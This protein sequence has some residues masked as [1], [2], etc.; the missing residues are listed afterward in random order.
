MTARC[1]AL[2]ARAAGLRSHLLDQAARQ[3]CARPHTLGG[4]ARELA[5]RGYPIESTAPDAPDLE[6]A[7]RRGAA[8]RLR[9]LARWDPPGN[10]TTILL[11]GEELRALR[12]LVRGAVEGLPAEARLAGLI[13]TPRLP[14]SGLDL[15]ARQT[16]V[17]DIAALLTR[18]RSPWAEAFAAARGTEPDLLA[19]ETGLGRLFARRT[20]AAASRSCRRLTEYARESVDLLNLRSAVLLAGRTDEVD[21][22]ALFLPG[23][24]LTRDDFLHTAAAPDGATLAERLGPR[25]GDTGLAEQLHRHAGEPTLLERGL[26]QWRLARWRAVART[27]PLT[28]APV[29]AYVLALQGEVT[30]LLRLT[31]SI[32]LG[33][34]TPGAEAAGVREAA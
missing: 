12:A 16:G 26:A 33:V 25:L 22:A 9:L 32:A 24:R 17:A 15:L 13:P 21:P 14:E 30:A 28:A 7:I 3:A 18:W 20:L 34:P 11:A 8:A 31:W 1:E 23:G 10:A 4:L 29:I 2:V 27:E 19:I 5:Q 6:T